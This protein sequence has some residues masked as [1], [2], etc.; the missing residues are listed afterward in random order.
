MSQLF[1]QPPP[2]LGNQYADD[3]FLIGYLQRKLPAEILR[4]IEGELSDMGSLAG[5]KLYDMQLEDRL[6]EPLLTQW[7]P[8][9]NRIDRI[10][11]TSLWRTAAQLA[12][13]SG[14]I[15]IPYEARHG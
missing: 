13:Q 3:R 1:T 5:G 12:A 7:D 4:Q 10:E 2:K 14:L 11:V 9:G 8:W 6:H 15:S